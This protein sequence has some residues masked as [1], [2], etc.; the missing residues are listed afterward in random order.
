MALQRQ[1]LVSTIANGARWEEVRP[2]NLIAIDMNGN[3]VEGIDQIERSAFH[4]HFALLEHFVCPDA[5]ADVGQ[6]RQPA[7]PRKRWSG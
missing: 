6:S 5:K 4:I 7:L 1:D 2:D 3:T